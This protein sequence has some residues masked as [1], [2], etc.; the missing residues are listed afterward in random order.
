VPDEHRGDDHR[1]RCQSL[2]PPAPS[3]GA[4][5]TVRDQQR[6]PTDSSNRIAANASDG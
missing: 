1:E 6:L 5:S 3:N 2:C 4:P